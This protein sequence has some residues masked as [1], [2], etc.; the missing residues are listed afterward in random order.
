[1]P[2]QDGR[3]DT[4]VF[5]GAR[6]AVSAVP[7]ASAWLMLSAGLGFLAWCARRRRPFVGL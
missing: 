2:G 1:M 5:D 7:E 6:V 4:L 3:I